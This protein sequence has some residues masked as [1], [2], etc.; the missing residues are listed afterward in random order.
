[1]WWR[2]AQNYGNFGLFSK[3][4]NHNT[5]KTSHRKTDSLIMESTIEDV[6]AHLSLLAD[7]EKS[8]KQRKKG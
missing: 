6:Y 7:T 5:N 2:T 3:D 1:L 8:E 4:E